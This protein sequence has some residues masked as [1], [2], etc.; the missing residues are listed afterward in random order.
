[1]KTAAVVGG[2]IAGKSGVSPG[3]TTSDSRHALPV[4]VDQ[5]RIQPAHG[6]CEYMLSRMDSR[7]R[8]VPT[9]AFYA[10]SIGY[11]C[12]TGA[13]L[14]E[15]GR[16][17]GEPRY[18]EA[19]GRI[20]RDTLKDR[21]G[22]LWPVGVFAE[23]PV[24][25]GLPVGWR[26]MYVDKADLC[27][28]A[29][30]I[31][32]LGVYY[33]ASGDESVVQIARAG[34]ADLVRMPEFHRNKDTT[35]HLT[36]EAVGLAVAAWEKKFPEFAL[37][38]G[39]ILQWV[40]DTFVS[41]APRDFPFLTMYRTMFVL[42]ETGSRYLDSHVR[43]GFDA[44][45]AEPRWRCPENRKDFFHIKD[46]ADHV[47][48]RGNGAIAITMRL[49]DLAAGTTIYTGSDVYRHV[50]AWIDGQRRDDGAYY[51]C[52]E[53]KLGRRYCLGSPAQYVPL[54]WLIG[55]L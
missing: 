50:T 32:A 15:A 21:I 41:T 14:A 28:S 27:Y 54:C 52:R 24:Y 18:I 45:L 51:G 6:V 9:E 43:P 53:H 42:N 20:L 49:I 22:N 1:M 2:G 12:S 30:M 3:S 29:L 31:A 7:G 25:R 5:S 4:R 19:G 46:S 39:P 16:L 33:R 36:F 23:Y 44:L 17:L 38:K 47:N 34:L 8:F 35:H 13:Y 40:L 48:I 55:G 37:H 11:R 10:E 26:E